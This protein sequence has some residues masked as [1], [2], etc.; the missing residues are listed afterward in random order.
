MGSIQPPLALVVE[1]DHLQRSALA[2]V[3]RDRGFEVI[4]CESE[5]AGELV[6]ARVGLELSVLV[7]DVDLGDGPSGLELTDFAMQRFPD[8][9]TII[10]SGRLGI[11]IPDK[12]HFL[13]KPFA[14]EELV[15]AATA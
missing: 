8:L 13:T 12:V 15:R 9:R 5:E 3:L 1:D 10:V 4:E 14:P 6:L 7:T 2:R 11:P